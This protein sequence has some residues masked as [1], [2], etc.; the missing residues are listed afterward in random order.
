MEKRSQR[1]KILTAALGKSCGKGAKQTRRGQRTLRR[2]DGCHLPSISFLLF[3]LTA[4]D[5]NYP[6]GR[7]YSKLNCPLVLTWG[8][9]GWRAPEVREDKAVLEEDYGKAGVDSVEERVRKEEK[10]S[11]VK[12]SQR[13]CFYREPYSVLNIEKSRSNQWICS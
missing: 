11:K 2:S 13:C 10:N 9:G 8:Y 12:M 1:Q 5:P 7:P 6:T 4:P 3:P